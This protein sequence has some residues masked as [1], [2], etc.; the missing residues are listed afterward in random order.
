MIYS[1][2]LKQK[3]PQPRCFFMALSF[4]LYLREVRRDEGLVKPALSLTLSLRERHVALNPF[5]PSE[6]NQ[7]PDKEANQDNTDNNKTG[8]AFGKRQYIG[9]HAIDTGHQHR[10][11]QHTW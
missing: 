8:G 7:R 5:L 6:V 11:C 10:W 4:S 9:V 2:A 1:S 3:A